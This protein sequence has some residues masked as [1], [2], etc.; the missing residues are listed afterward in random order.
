[1]TPDPG[2]DA[3]LSMPTVRERAPAP[4]GAAPPRQFRERPDFRFRWLIAA[5]AGTVPA[6]LGAEPVPH[7]HAVLAAPATQLQWDPTPTAI[8]YNVYFGKDRQAVGEATTD[9]PFHLAS[10]TSTFAEIPADLG[11]GAVRY[12]RV[13]ALVDGLTVPGT[14]RDFSGRLELGEVFPGSEGFYQLFDHQLAIDGSHAFAGFPEWVR[15]QQDARPGQVRVFRHSPSSDTWSLSQVLDKPAGTA[16]N[17]RFG[18]ALAVRDGVGWIGAPSDGPGSVFQYRLDLATGLWSPTSLRLRSQSPIQGEL[19]GATLALGNNWIAVGVLRGANGQTGAID[20][21]DSTSGAW[22]ARLLSRVPNS[23]TYFAQKIAGDGDLLAVMDPGSRKLEIHERRADGSWTSQASLVPNGYHPDQYA[24]TSFALSGDVLLIGVPSRDSSV[25]GNVYAYERNEDGSWS[26]GN[27]FRPAGSAA[28]YAR[29]AMRGDRAA[30]HF[31][32]SAEDEPTVAIWKREADKS[33]TPLGTTTTTAPEEKALGAVISLALSDRFLIQS[34][35]VSNQARLRLYTHNADA[36]VPPEFSSTPERFAEEQRPYVYTVEAPDSNT[37]DGATLAALSV[38]AWLTFAANGSGRATL[39][40]TPP[41]GSA[42]TVSI[43]L[44]AT[45]QSGK[46]AIQAFDLRVVPPGGLPV[47]GSLSPDLSVNDHERLELSVE[48]TDSGPAT[49]QWYFEGLVLPGATAANLVI[50]HA[51]AANAGLYSVRITRAPAEVTSPPIRVSVLPVADRFG[52][53]WSTVGA[54]TSHSG[55]YPAT[56]ATHT[57]LPAWSKELAANGSSVNQAV[58]SDGRVFASITNYSIAA[59]T[60]RAFDLETGT[61]L[62]TRG[63]P[64]GNYLTQPAVHRGLVLVQRGAPQPDLRGFDASSGAPRW[65]LTYFDQARQPYVPAVGDE[66]VFFMTGHGVGKASLAGTLAWNVAALPVDRWTPLIHQGRVFLWQSGRFAEIRAA[67]GL[68][69]WSLSLPWTAW[70]TYSTISVAAAEGDLVAVMDAAS[71]TVIRLSTRSVVWSKR[72]SFVPSSPAIGDGLVYAITPGAVATYR[73]SDGAEMTPLPTQD[74][75]G[76]SRTAIGQPIILDDHIL[77]SSA[78]ETWVIDRGSHATVQRLPAGGPLSYANGVLMVAGQDGV[79]RAF[80]VNQPP[81][82]GTPTQTFS[83]IEDTVASWTLPVSDPDGDPLTID[84]PHRPSWMRLTE[85]AGV[86]AFEGLPTLS[87]QAGESEFTVRVADGKSG[88]TS[89]IVRISVTAVND[90]PTAA[91]PSVITID[92]DSAVPTVRL[93]E[94]FDDEEDTSAGLAFELDTPPAEAF[95]TWN[96]DPVTGEFTSTTRPDFNGTVVLSFRARDTGGSVASTS[97]TLTITPVPDAPRAPATLPA[98]DVPP[99]GRP[100]SLELAPSFVDADRGDVLRFSVISNDQPD[101]FASIS[102][103]AA[104]GRLV[105]TWND[106]RWGTARLVLRGTDL[107]GLFAD[108]VLTVT[109][110]APP[111]PEVGLRGSARLNRQTGLV[112]QVVIVR[113]VAPR[114]IGGFNLWVDGGPGATLFNGVSGAS[115]TPEPAAPWAVP[116]AVPLAAGAEAAIVLEF[117]AA[118]RAAT[119]STHGAQVINGNPQRL[120]AGAEDGTTPVSRIV[121][122]SDGLLI[123]FPSV[124][125]TAYLIEFSSDNRTW[126]VSPIPIRAGGTAVQWIDRGPPLTPTPPAAAASRYYRVRAHQT[127]TLPLE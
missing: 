114:A 105:L 34:A 74:T 69:L 33:W 29:V 30:I 79:L 123:E 4:A 9:S 43:R 48:L 125:G 59:P 11:A 117:H 62:W 97:V 110:P 66:G 95:A 61:D 112:E 21:F 82:L 50:E 57:F 58:T 91:A 122:T 3:D 35:T 89:Q 2:A 52:G 31:P 72:G 42:G 39:S 75:A 94:L 6:L 18:A 53:D 19:F 103:D 76:V 100:V 28:S 63:L 68:T 26:L 77:V 20:I 22:Q 90:P 51:Q 45:D 99:D 23:G 41:A 78:T 73:A 93:R 67:D 104:T 116:Y 13:D 106:F 107:D 127:P 27:A 101:L 14:V 54:S 71:L 92:E 81:T 113:N 56:L 15:T 102:L 84:A 98:P 16:A 38:P 86:L 126:T 44:M 40:G 111:E 46:S 64:I 49:Y 36:N 10:T 12:W 83:W 25:A 47:I 1:M 119:P 17:A 120:P 109:L 124:P 96:L 121:A 70:E 87:S 88:T 32:E 8:R 7:N 5:A 65:T 118:L 24:A 60:I 85:S 80:A 55:R 115:L 37:G 108:T